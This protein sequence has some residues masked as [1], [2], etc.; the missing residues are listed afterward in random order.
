MDRLIGR[1]SHTKWCCEQSCCASRKARRLGLIL[2]FMR[3]GK[4]ASQAYSML[5]EKSRYALGDPRCRTRVSAVAAVR[6][7]VWRSRE[8]TRNA[9][10]DRDGGWRAAVE[11]SSAHP[12]CPPESGPGLFCDSAAVTLQRSLA[13]LLA[14]IFLQPGQHIVSRIWLGHVY[15]SGRDSIRT[16]L[17]SGL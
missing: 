8:K 13:H 7:G 16:F 10:S 4:T 5:D 9:V 2:I 3:K 1:D 15:S 12:Q 14:R 6:R 11:P 17:S